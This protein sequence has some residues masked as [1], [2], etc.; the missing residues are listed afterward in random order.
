VLQTLHDHPI[1]TGALLQGDLV[2]TGA[3]LT[4]RLEPL[5]LEEI[6]RVWDA[7]ETSYQLCVSYEVSLVLVAS[8]EEVRRISPV[9]SVEPEY[10][11]IT[12]VNH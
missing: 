6:T 4:I 3:Q 2:G 9:E 1:L 11:V 12:G 5:G 10:G 8:D 7:L